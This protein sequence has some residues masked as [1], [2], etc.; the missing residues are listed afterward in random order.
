VGELGSEDLTSPRF[1]G[2]PHLEAVFDGQE[3]MSFGW[4]GCAVKKVQQALIEAGFDVGEF[5]VDGDF[6]ERT[7]A[8]VEGFQVAQGLVSDGVVGP[9]TLR[10][11]E[12]A[13]PQF[14]A[15][16]VDCAEPPLLPPA[17]TPQGGS[18]NENAPNT[19]FVFRVSII[20]DGLEPEVAA[21]IASRSPDTI[22]H[23][24]ARWELSVFASSGTL[25]HSDGG[26]VPELQPNGDG[27]VGSTML[28]LPDDTYTTAVEVDLD[29]VFQDSNVRFFTIVGGRLFE[30]SDDP[31]NVR[32]E[33]RFSELP[34]FS[35][36]LISYSGI[37]QGGVAALAGSIIDVLEIVTFEGHELIPVTQTLVLPEQL[38]VG[39]EYS[40]TFV[41]PTD[42]EPGRYP[43]KVTMDSER[44]RDRF[45]LHI[46]IQ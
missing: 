32:A 29:G 46:G 41:V 15:V 40:G 21:K 18:R 16:P 30:L 7:K 33:I 25:V 1:A 14:S 35:A 45:L 4:F 43:A 12:A 22:A 20:G 23:G 2:E 26:L 6:G 44:T 10:A 39:H 28:A 37:N 3:L 31:R 9:L 42:L 27:F 34:V 5:G 36:G 8:A 19:L 17:I 24:R 13:V 38:D 11:L